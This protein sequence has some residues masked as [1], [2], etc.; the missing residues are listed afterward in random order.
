MEVVFLSEWHE[1]HFCKF[2]VAAWFV[3]VEARHAGL[4]QGDKPRPEPQ[5]N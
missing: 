4:P 2:G 5:I 1:V 3:D